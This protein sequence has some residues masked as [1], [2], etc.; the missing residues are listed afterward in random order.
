MVLPGAK[1]TRGRATWAKNALRV[2]LPITENG[3]P[4]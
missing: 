4:D 3:V 1:L 2:G